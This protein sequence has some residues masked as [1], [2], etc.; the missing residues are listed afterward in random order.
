MSAT[1]SN[2]QASIGLGLRSSASLPSRGDRRPGAWRTLAATL[3]ATSLGSS[4]ALAAPAIQ[5]VTPNH[6]PPGSLITVEGAGFAPSPTANFVTF[7]TIRAIVTQA[8]SNALTVRVPFGATVQPITVT[9]DGL[10][11]SSP[12]PFVPTFTK[13]GDLS[14]NT[15]GPPIRLPSLATPHGILG[16][17]DGDGWLDMVFANYHASSLSVLRNAAIEAT[18]STNSFPARLDLPAGNGP[19]TPAMADLDGDG[20]MELIVPNDFSANVSVYQNLSSP[21][22]LNAASIAARVNF[23]TRNNPVHVRPADIDGDGKPDLVVVNAVVGPSTV[24]VHRNVSVR[25]TLNTDSFAAGVHFPTGTHSFWNEVGD[26]DGDGKPDVVVANIRQSALSILRNTS[27]PGIIDEHTFA[28]A[29][30]LSLPAAPETVVLADFDGDGKLDIAAQSSGS[31]Y[32]LRNLS[33]GG[34]LSP[35]SFAQPYTIPSGGTELKAADFDGDGR[36]DV[37]VTPIV[38]P[39]TL[40]LHLNFSEPGSLEFGPHINLLSGGERFDVGDLNG[41]GSPDLAVGADT[42]IGSGLFLIENTIPVDPEAV[43]GNPDPVILSNPADRV[44]TLGGTTTFGVRASGQQPLKYQWHFSGTIIPDGTNRALT[45]TNLAFNQAG[46]YH[47]IVANDFGAATSS[48]ATLAVVYP[49]ATVRVPNVQAPGGLVTLPVELVANGNENAAAFSLQ[50]DPSRAS[51]VSAR[52]GDD[53]LGASLVINTNSKGRE[54]IGFTIALPPG[55]TFAAGVRQIALVTLTLSAGSGQNSGNYSTTLGLTDSPVVR[56]LTDATNAA[57][58]AIYENGTLT[59]LVSTQ[60]VASVETSTGGSVAVPVTLRALGIENAASFSL[61][62]NPQMLSFTGV[63]S[64]FGM[65]ADAALLVNTNELGGGR[66]GLSLALP[67]GTAWTAGSHEMVVIHFDVATI[68]QPSST[69][70]L[71]GDSPI[72]RQVANT[73]AQP[74]A[75]A[76]QNGTVSVKTIAFEGDVAPRPDGD[77]NLSVIDWAQVGRFVAALD[78]IDPGEFQR[79]DCAPRSTRGNG[80]IS[81]S[82]W[83]QAGRYSARLDPITGRGGPIALVEGAAGGG[84]AAGESLCRVALATTNVLPGTTLSVPVSIASAG[85]ENA[86]GFSIAFDPTLLRYLSAAL[87]PAVASATLQLNTNRADLGRVGVAIATSPGAALEAGSRELVLLNFSASATATGST[88]LRFADTPVWREA[89]GVSATALPSA[90]VDG[91]VTFGPPP[92]VGPVLSIRRSGTSIL[93]DWPSADPGFALYSSDAPTGQPW[94]KVTTAPILVGDR[95]LIVV[96]GGNDDHRYFRLEKA[97]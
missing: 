59:M 37:A 61:S 64:G 95:E 72:V 26:L 55:Q 73:N 7:G 42:A 3:V 66:L 21:G 29:F 9:S 12:L 85:G 71:F 70:I 8:T 4:T 65:P 78:E 39:R 52:A 13:R 38:F 83:V 63:E 16:D 43:T 14:T 25:G 75:A 96:P 47:V 18:L 2:H 92:L 67:A 46:A 77:R 5:S 1:T 15:F 62:F 81:V 74:T 36:P 94:T 93:L 87:S 97:H 89:A 86:V 33:T 50:V 51:Y 53:A 11:V 82:D 34:I 45:L 35:G 27:V 31:T 88:T 30:L 10:M 19:H 90:F 69:T 41:D 44:A 68:L 60:Q 28:P 84:L 57:L 6:G 24:S 48:V 32:I 23:P 17:V 80:V 56:A 79:V 54:N 49:P 58:A 40:H 20:R 76:Y 91:L 22:N